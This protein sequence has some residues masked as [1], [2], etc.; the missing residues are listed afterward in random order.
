[1]VEVEG[2]RIG[3]KKKEEEDTQSKGKKKKGIRKK[4]K[5]PAEIAG[6]RPGKARYLFTTYDTISPGSVGQIR[7]S[8]TETSDTEHYPKPN[9]GFLL[10]NRNA[11]RICGEEKITNRNTM[12]KDGSAGLT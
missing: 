4:R 10:T 11:L 5:K 2:R 1:M 6:P 7:L 8:Q 12:I 3:G 9:D